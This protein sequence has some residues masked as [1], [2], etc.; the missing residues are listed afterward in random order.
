MNQKGIVLSGLVYVLLTF[1]IL[2]LVSFLAVLWYRQNALDA[3]HKDADAIYDDIYI[4]EFS[5]EFDYTG[6]VQ[7]FVVPIDGNYK[8]ELW[9]AQG[10]TSKYNS[11]GTGSD[12]PG[13][14]GGYTAGTIFLKVNQILY[15]YVGGKGQNGAPSIVAT[16]GYNGGGTGGA[17]YQGGSGGGGATDIRLINGTWNNITS[18]RSR[19]IVAGGGGGASNWVNA[20]TGGHAGGL[21]GSDGLLNVGSISHPLPTGGTQTTGGLA[22]GT[23]GFGSPGSFGVGG[24]SQLYHGGG[25]GSGYY[26][27][28][29]A[30]FTGGGVSS[31]AGGSSFISGY[32]GC[33][34][35]DANGNHTGGPNHYSGYIFNNGNMTDGATQMTSPTGGL[36]TG[37]TGNGYAKITYLP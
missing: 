20:V 30:G 6:N 17:S 10:G 23:A 25:G 27:G 35:I 12:V 11:D 14:T 18:L 16:G 28:G 29:G 32:S 3:L 26:G 15:V 5:K 36:E 21:T 8:I 1:F 31:G 33:N 37:H 22:G 2:L 7:T 19:I 4:S 24:N 9:G 13:G 34:A